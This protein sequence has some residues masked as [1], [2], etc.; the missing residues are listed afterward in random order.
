MGIGINDA[1][2]PVQPRVN[3]KKTIRCPF[4]QRWGGMLTRAYSNILHEQRP[5]YRG[6]SVDPRW[7]S[8]MNF[9]SWMEKQDW[10]GKELDKDILIYSN[11]VYGPDTC[12]FVSSKVNSFIN[13]NGRRRSEVT[14]QYPGVS[15]ESKVS[16]WR[17]TGNSVDT[18]KSIHLGCFETAEEAYNAWKKF[19]LEQAYILIEQESLESRV[20]EA[21]INRYK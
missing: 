21:L 12:V 6:C 9:R 3:G 8:F 13:I 1:D 10:E 18:G 19:K 20:A 5:S 17:G 16:K 11:K 4:Y 7:H 2:Y 15:W 14:S